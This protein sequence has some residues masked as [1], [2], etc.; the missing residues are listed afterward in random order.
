MYVD[1]GSL[2]DLNVAKSE[3]QT[4]IGTLY[5]ELGAPL[6]D[7]KRLYMAT[8]NEFLGVVHDVSQA[9]RGGYVT[10]WPKEALVEKVNGYIRQFRNTNIMH[11]LGS[12]RPFQCGI[13]I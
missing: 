5:A 2:T 1:D 6:A 12:P 4:L 13:P 9:V 3:G 7:G 8:S 11:H 10:F